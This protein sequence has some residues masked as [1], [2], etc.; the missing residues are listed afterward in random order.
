[1]C[2]LLQ[3]MASPPV[4]GASAITTR[5]GEG[6]GRANG[7]RALPAE[8]WAPLFARAGSRRRRERVMLVS[9]CK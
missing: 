5:P 8:H 9:R 4:S 7:E 6:I 1:M 3:A 2:L